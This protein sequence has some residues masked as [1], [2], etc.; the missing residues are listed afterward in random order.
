MSEVLVEARDGV[1][2][3]YA[4]TGWSLKERW[5]KQGEL[6]LLVFGSED[7]QEGAKAFAEKRAP[8]S[9]GR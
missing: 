2:I 5:A 1:Q 3:A 8:V 4:A 7:A 9:K 6:V